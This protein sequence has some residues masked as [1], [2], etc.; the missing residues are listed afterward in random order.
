MRPEPEGVRRVIMEQISY[1]PYKEF[2]TII[3][4]LLMIVGGLW[5]GL[6]AWNIIEMP[7]GNTHILDHILT[8]GLIYNVEKFIFPG[9]VLVG[10][11]NLSI[12]E[13]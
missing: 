5:A 13:R 2:R 3:G 7:W 1:F 6:G 9:L 8:E 4:V 10:L 11:G 12:R